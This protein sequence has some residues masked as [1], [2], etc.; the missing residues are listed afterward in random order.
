M[1]LPNSWLAVELCVPGR[2]RADALRDMNRVLRTQYKSNRLSEWVNGK[3]PIP[4]P[5]RD[6]MMRIAIEWVLNQ[7]GIEGLSDEQLD[8]IVERLT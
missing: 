2:T 8:R 6:Y 1:T 4:D 7:E 3:R 5:V